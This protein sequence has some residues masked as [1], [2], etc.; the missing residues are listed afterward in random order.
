[1]PNASP[2]RSMRVGIP[3]Q[4]PVLRGTCKM[5]TARST[6]SN[7]QVGQHVSKQCACAG[8]AVGRRRQ[9]ANRACLRPSI[10]ASWPCGPLMNR[11]AAA[12]HRY[13]CDTPSTAIGRWHTCRSH[14]RSIGTARPSAQHASPEDDGADSVPPGQSCFHTADFFRR[15]PVSCPCHCLAASRA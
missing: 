4:R 6:R 2:T 15:S 7:K 13:C 5:V 11:R 14:S 10:S 1:M 9:S 12:V 3:R 8:S